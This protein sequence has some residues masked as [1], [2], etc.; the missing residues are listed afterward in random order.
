LDEALGAT[1]KASCRSGLDPRAPARLQNGPKSDNGG[2]VGAR[3]IRV[4]PH[5]L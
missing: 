1:S 3:E 5:P 4:F 2:F